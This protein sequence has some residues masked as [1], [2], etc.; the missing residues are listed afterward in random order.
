MSPRVRCIRDGAKGAGREACR[1]SCPP[2]LAPGARASP[3][4]ACAS[5]ACAAERA[6]PALPPTVGRAPPGRPERMAGQRAVV[7]D[8]RGPGAARGLGGFAFLGGGTPAEHACWTP[9][10]SRDTTDRTSAAPTG[11]WCSAQTPGTTAGPLRATLDARLSEGRMSDRATC[12]G[13]PRATGQTHSPPS[14]LTAKSTRQP[15]VL[16]KGVRTHANRARVWCVTQ[17]RP[18]WRAAS[19]PSL[20]TAAPAA[21]QTRAHARPASR[22]S[23]RPRSRRRP[24]P[25]REPR[26]QHVRKPRPLRWDTTYL[27]ADAATPDGWSSGTRRL[28]QGHVRATVEARLSA[29]RL[30][31][32]AFRLNICPPDSIVFRAP[33]PGPG[34]LPDRPQPPQPPCAS[35]RPERT[36]GRQGFVPDKR[37]CVL[38]ANGRPSPCPSLSSRLRRAIGNTGSHRPT[39]RESPPARCG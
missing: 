2:C 38:A 39:P 36:A 33:Q 4:A 22:C 23:R 19:R 1:P 14:R 30:S 21:R 6:R 20:L 25:R 35:E 3:L 34:W 26:A 9:Y 24:G 15:G 12:L 11:D 8:D 13:A 7:P 37:V 16:P 5:V 29:A 17:R 32:R 27:A 28:R 31:H 10:E 18:R